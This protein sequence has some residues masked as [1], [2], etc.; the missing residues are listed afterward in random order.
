MKRGEIGGMVDDGREVFDGGL[1]LGRYGADEQP[2][3]GEDVRRVR[4]R[5]FLRLRSMKDF[6]CARIV[7]S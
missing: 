1:V 5:L 3:V 2:G 7:V 6:E 4:R